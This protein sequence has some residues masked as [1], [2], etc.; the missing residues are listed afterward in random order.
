MP[1]PSSLLAQNWAFLKCY[2]SLTA[3]FCSF[4]SILWASFSIFFRCCSMNRFSLSAN[5]CCLERKGKTTTERFTKS[6]SSTNWWDL[7]M[8]TFNYT[9]TTKKRYLAPPAGHKMNTWWECK[10][11]S[12]QLDYNF[13]CV[14]KVLFFIQFR[15]K[16][17]LWSNFSVVYLKTK[18]F[19]K[20]LC[21]IPTAGQLFLWN[22]IH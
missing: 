13:C 14:H 3:I 2:E 8:M 10:E 1:Q 17:D 12:L 15:F 9:Q 20:K 4:F 21:S 11:K 16:S 5:F 22:Q 7:I 6:I 19:I 18:T